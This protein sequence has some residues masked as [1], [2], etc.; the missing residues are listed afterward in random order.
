MCLV[1]LLNANALSWYLN[2]CVLHSKHFKLIKFELLLYIRINSLFSGIM[3]A[4]FWY[5]QV[6]CFSVKIASNGFEAIL[7][8]KLMNK[9]VFAASICILSLGMLCFT[10]SLSLSISLALCS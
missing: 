9:I 5:I 1:N 3:R 2:T 7:L 10:L 4:T 8:F 6:V